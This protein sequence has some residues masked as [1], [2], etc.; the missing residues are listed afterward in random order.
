M[1]K[2]FFV[3]AFT[4]GTVTTVSAQTKE[5]T[6]TWLKDKMKAYGN[7]ASSAKKISIKSIDECKIVV[8]YSLYSKDK[9]G[10]EK[11]LRFEEILPTNIDRILHSNDKFPGHFVY[12]EENVITNHDGSFLD[13]SRTSSLRLDD[14]MVDIPD[15][16]RM[17]KH[18]ATFCV[19][20]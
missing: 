5:E 4:A 13:K 8:H 16:E 2:L 9:Q 18:L 15:V 20:K 6:I 7:N 17:I 14:E 3:L 19:K 1:K 11:E 10:K 12:R